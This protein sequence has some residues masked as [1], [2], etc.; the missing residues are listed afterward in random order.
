MV[1]DIH[2]LTREMTVRYRK[3]LDEYLAIDNDKSDKSKQMWDEMEFLSALIEK[4]G[5]FLT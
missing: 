4:Y 5:A 2:A 1:N 3:L